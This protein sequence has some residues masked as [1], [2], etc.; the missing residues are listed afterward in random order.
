METVSKGFFKKKILEQKTYTYKSTGS[1]YVGTMLGGFRHGKGLMEW[2]D[3]AKYDGEWEYGFAQ[4]YGT[5]YH[6]DGDVYSGYWVNSK[7]NG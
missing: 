1:I 6:V 4:G 2:T 5:F 7:C 3:G